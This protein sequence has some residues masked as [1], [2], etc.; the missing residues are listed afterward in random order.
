MIMIKSAAQARFLLFGI[1]ILLDAVIF[2]RGFE[3]QPLPEYKHLEEFKGEVVYFFEG[4]KSKEQQ[5]DRFLVLR[6]NNNQSNFFLGLGDYLD[7]DSSAYQE[8]KRAINVG[9]VISLKAYFVPGGLLT[10]EHY[11]IVEFEKNNNVVLNYPTMVSAVQAESDFNYKLFLFLNIVV[12]V[13]FVISLIKSRAGDGGG[14]R[15]FE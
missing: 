5:S 10:G 3:L 6:I 14:D 9:Y 11:N 15:S 4:I 7:D 1:F 13:L 8:V 2:L 12:I